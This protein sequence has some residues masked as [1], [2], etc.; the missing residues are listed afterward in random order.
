[1]SYFRQFIEGL[2]C[3]SQVIKPIKKKNEKEQAPIKKKMK[4]LVP[5][6]RDYKY[7]GRNT[8]KKISD[9]INHANKKPPS[10]SHSKARFLKVK[11]EI[12]GRN[13]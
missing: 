7:K 13:F 4:A 2:V 5:K 3:F 12:I 6:S 9:V 8:E 10:Y 11:F 1:M